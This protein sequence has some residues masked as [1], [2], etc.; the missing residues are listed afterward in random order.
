MTQYDFLNRKGGCIIQIKSHDEL[1]LARALV[2]GRAYVNRKNPIYKWESIRKGDTH[3]YT[4]QKIEAKKLMHAA[5]LTNHKGPCGIPEIEKLQ[6][7]MPEYQIKIHDKD[8]DYGIFYKGIPLG[9]LYNFHV[10]M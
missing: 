3:R 5:K 9:L 4:A 1:C 8:R 6:S 10:Y 7:V 2:V